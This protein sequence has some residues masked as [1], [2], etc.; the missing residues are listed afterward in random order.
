VDD[1][2]QMATAGPVKFKTFIDVNLQLAR[3]I[4]QLSSPDY[5]LRKAAVLALARQP[6][7][8]RAALKKSRIKADEPTQWWIAAALQEIENQQRKTDAGNH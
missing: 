1:Q 5:E 3:L 4:A 6:V 8:A 2:L 7:T